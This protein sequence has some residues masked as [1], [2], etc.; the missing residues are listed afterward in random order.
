MSASVKHTLQTYL[1]RLTNLSGNNRSLVLLRL[2]A[3]QLLDVHEFSFLN[4]DR[5]FEI[6]NALIAGRNKKLCQVLDSRIEANNE[7]SKKLKR[8][9]RIDHFIFEERGSNDLHI[10]WPFVRGKFA[11]GSIVRCPLLFFPVSLVQEGQHWVLQLR[12]DAGISLNK[13]FL[14]A[15]SFFNK[16]KLDEELM[17]TS[18]DDFSSD[19][20]VFRTQLYQ[21]LKDKVEINFNPDNFRDELVPFQEYK[22][23]A[24]D[25]T[26][27]N[28][29]L[30]L[31]PESV[32]GIFPQ[33]GSQLVPD[34]LH[35]IENNSITDLEEFFLKK[36]TVEDDESISSQIIYQRP[37][38]EE[39]LFTP[40]VLDA[41]Q[42]NA[43]K[44]IKNGQ[45]IVVQGPPGTGKSQLICNL[46]ADAIASGKKALLVC[47][48][49]AALDV[50]YDRLHVLGVGDFL[51]LVHDFRNDRKE[52]FSAINNQIS[53]VEE[54]KARNRSIDVILSERKFY[55]VCR[56]IDQ[57][58]EELD[59]F[60]H[61][62]FD[63]KECG[64]SVKELYLTS[65]LHHPTINIKQ[66]YQYFSIQELSEFVRKLKEYSNYASW[67]D[68]EDYPWRERKTFATFRLSDEKEIEHAVNDIPIYQKQLCD[69]IETLI[70]V[71]LGLEEAETL[72]FKED[73]ILGMIASLKDDE[74][75]RFFQ[76]MISE[77]DDETSI[78]WLSN[79]ER[80]S[81][82]CF[83]HEN[84][85]ATIISDQLG[86]FQEVLQYRMKAR[87]NFIRLIRWELFSDDTF[88]VK[89]VLVANGLSYNKI[90]LNVLEQRIDSRLNL[91]HH[92]TALKDKTWLI[93]LPI[94]YKKK[95]LQD[96]FE[97]QKFAIRAKIVF[98]SLR[99]IKE[100]IK[101]QMYSR[102]EYIDMLLEA[103]SIVKNV[104][105]R[106][107]IW[108]AH[109]SPYQV[110]QLSEDAGLGSIY[111]KSLRKDFDNLCEYDKLKEELTTTEKS[112]VNKLH[113]ELKAWDAKQV[114]VLFQNSVRL[115]WIDHIETKYPILRSVSS[116]KMEELARELQ[117]SVIEKQKLSKEI[118]MVRARE[119]V[120]DELEYNRLNNLVTY[121]DLQHQVSKKKKVW[122][123]RKVIAEFQNEVFQLIPCWMASPESVSA[124][125]PM[126][127]LFDLV[128]FDEA[129]QCFSERGVPAMY[130]GKQ[131]L[132][133]GDEKQ[134][135]PSE[136]YHVRW[137][138]D[139]EN[140]DLEID[141]LLELTERYLPTVHL[142]GHY[143]SQSVELIDFSN[144]F[145]YEGRLKL[146]PDR[147]VFNR[148][149]PAI[150]YR[151]IEGFWEHQTNVMEATAVVECVMNTVKE[152]PDK[153]IGV[154]TFNAPQQMLI[155]DI[156]ESEA[157][158]TGQTLPSSLFVKNIENVQGDEKDIIIFSVGYAPDKKGKMIM[159]FGSLN[160]AGGE[161]R[162]NVAVTRA[163]E[164]IILFT[165]IW[166]E[167]LSVDDIKND[168]PKLLRK[169]L[170]YVRQVDRKEYR[171]EQLPLQ[172]NQ[173]WY[174]SARL[175]QWA[176]DRLKE[177][178]FE[179]HVL[180]FADVPIRLD[181]QYIGLI[182]TDDGRYF[183]S[184]SPKDIYAYT[185]ALLTQKNWKYFR[186]Y[187]RN[188]WK[189]REKMERDLM[190]FIGSQ[191]TQ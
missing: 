159:Q 64:I 34:Y 121:R 19:S 103:L 155:L 178:A 14:L 111:I 86:K 13:S 74:T 82:N 138:G 174:L 68:T 88:L 67:F 85:E 143:R 61:A 115:A 4:G 38:N 149:E 55:Q 100:G 5:S 72:H 30:K 29:E 53:R 77:K 99:E 57:L 43:I 151:K 118:L 177:Y 54:Y 148:Q 94:D 11:D 27:R 167:Q 168:G 46:L 136:L 96:W 71:K 129:S 105:E 156:L 15:F 171:Q 36:N 97:K 79:I 130:R 21:L 145:F 191:V 162:L 124:I 119:R 32:L 69:R 58:T 24:F 65:D 166:P 6:I 154:V 140:P 3:E 92:L 98:N 112:V 172:Q 60:K 10:G 142:Q 52:I 78:L 84:P 26:H 56:K 173:H 165:S 70:G 47:Q 109:L 73:D 108:L 126:S 187:S 188:L 89:R 90:G 42:E 114:E 185:P 48:K 120:Y 144:A 113:N 176:T 190:I 25:E 76:S 83:G 63:D 102:K 45:S 147:H 189:D 91:E 35:L 116:I 9:Q 33:A 160:A 44:A 81:L 183:S 186:V 132:V 8:L 23:D 139:E 184:L 153:T 137:D 161:N 152:Q 179:N 131:I 157:M 150:E 41:F 51:G 95:S 104:P 107:K 134:L 106:K 141:S 50:V 12:E 117:A 62:L 40:F 175:Q 39:K 125:F 75:F 18:F 163:R 1:R 93:G 123:L 180:P 170:E 2:H 135:R 28:G 181:N 133:A 128:I 49:R 59:E 110:R 16:V 7:A 20:T 169:Y 31:Y 122:P 80:V 164:K 146:L 17:D 37:V 101:V 127:E 22:K 87:K 158:K 66:E 182:L